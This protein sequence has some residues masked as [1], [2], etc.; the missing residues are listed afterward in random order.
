M[1]TYGFRLFRVT[2]RRENGRKEVPFAVRQEG[3]TWRYRDHAAQLLEKHNGSRQRGFPQESEITPDT[4]AT[5]GGEQPVFSVENVAL[6]GEHIVFAVRYGRKSG[7]DVAMAPPEDPNA[8]DLDIAA[9]SPSRIY[10]A[11]LLLPETGDAGVLAVESVG[12]A[13]PRQAIIRWLNAWSRL[14]SPSST[15]NA[16]ST[17]W[18]KLVAEALGDE[19]LLESFMDRADTE[20]LILTRKGVTADNKRKT[21]SLKLTIDANRSEVKFG[22]TTIARSWG[23]TV[24]RGEHVSSSG[25]AHALAALIGADVAGI[26]F[27]DATVVLRDDQN[28]VKY[29]KPD[30]LSD[31]FVYRLTH[32][33]PPEDE[34]FHAGVREAVERVSTS[35]SLSFVW[36]GWPV[37]RL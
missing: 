3:A 4:S 8:Q 24:R 16:Q 32:D 36:S 26:D 21:D 23:P 1:T 37:G 10:R 9:H 29:I 6:M 27:D 18:W 14:E 13:C 31:V 19:S 12:N 30:R 22:A 11:A 35:A 15:G 5:W 2:L 7:H 34:R 33:V 17:P 20:Q 28:V 25:A